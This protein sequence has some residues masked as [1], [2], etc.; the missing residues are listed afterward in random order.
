MLLLLHTQRE[1]HTYAMKKII[2]TVT[3]KK[4]FNI[5]ENIVSNTP[6]LKNKTELRVAG[7][8]VRDKILGIDSDDIDISI[9]NMTGKDFATIL[10]KQLNHDNGHFPDSYIVK[11]NPAKSKHLETAA[12]KVD[13]V[14]IDFVHLRGET[15]KNEFSRIPSTTFA[16][17]EQ[18]VRRR[19]FTINSL[20]YNI[21]TKHVEDFSGY[22]LNDIKNKI[23]RTTPPRNSSD[24]LLE[25][26]L[27]A[28]RALRFASTLDFSIAD[29]LEHALLESNIHNAVLKKVSR[30]RITMELT[31]TLS[32][33]KEHALRGL[34][35]LNE[36]NLGGLLF[37]NDDDDFENYNY[38][39]EIFDIVCKKVAFII[40][41]LPIKSNE[42]IY[43]IFPYLFASFLSTTTTTN[44][45]TAIC[46]LRG[47]KALLKEK[48]IEKPMFDYTHDQFLKVQAASSPLYIKMT[49]SSSQYFSYVKKTFNYDAYLFDKFRGIRKDYIKKAINTYK[50]SLVFP[51]DIL[52]QHLEKDNIIDAKIVFALWLCNVRLFLE[53]E[54]GKEV[55]NDNIIAAVCLANISSVDT[56]DLSS[57]KEIEKVQKRVETMIDF[58]QKHNLLNLT[59]PNS[60][61]L[62][63]KE[64]IDNV[65]KLNANINEKTKCK[66]QKSINKSILN[67]RIRIMK[68]SLTMWT[69]INNILKC[70]G[71]VVES[72]ED[73]KEEAYTFLSRLLDD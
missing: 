9:T 24:V 48:I 35:M 34:N 63:G 33:P 1:R 10:K 29:E 40:T 32:L 65:K 45:K 11:L 47:N 27:R 72:E 14:W 44:D 49:D 23:I 18:D 3:E 73:D 39:N 30:E 51:V 69:A 12:V 37:G 7:G 28:Y 41:F 5:L 55:T 52:N 42:S 68:D 4:I 8:W 36:Y 59:F 54:R 16:T 2:T 62:N 66:K 25:D 70:D 46:F 67:D 38:N 19:D 20:F 50:A 6:M 64:V 22:G 60:P 58:Y 21:H 56:Y 71:Y 57:E 13:N 31:K 61:I 15:Y 53:N 17:P 43:E 26:P